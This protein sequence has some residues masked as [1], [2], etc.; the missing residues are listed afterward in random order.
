MKAIRDP[1][2]NEINHLL[3]ACTFEGKQVLEIGC[4][5]SYVT[6]GY[7]HLVSQA[8]GIDLDLNS[9]RKAQGERPKDGGNASFLQASGEAL[10]F[11]PGCFDTVLFASSL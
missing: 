6:R 10:P 1:E 5:D 2:R 9:L 11:P 4:G 7:A 8:V 3:A